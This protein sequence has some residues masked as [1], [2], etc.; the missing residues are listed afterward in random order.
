M[1]Y[2]PEHVVLVFNNEPPSLSLLPIEEEEEEVCVDLPGTDKSL[3]KFKK[4]QNKRIHCLKIKQKGKCKNKGKF[5][6]TYKGKDDDKQYRGMKFRDICP[7][8]CNN[9]P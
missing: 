4:K 1:I 2:V 5:K 9:C 6:S 8:S 3:F 7:K